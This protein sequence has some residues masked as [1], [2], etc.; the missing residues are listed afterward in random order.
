MGRPTKVSFYLKGAVRNQIIK[1]ELVKPKTVFIRF[2]FLGKKYLYYLPFRIAQEDWDFGKQRI[3][4]SAI[5]QLPTELNQKFN[6]I[7]IA[8]G[9]LFNPS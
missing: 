5:N 2:T 6:E 8:T 3:K 7:E 1:A 4:I 9:A